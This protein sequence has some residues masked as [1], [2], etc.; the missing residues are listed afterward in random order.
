AGPDPQDGV[1]AELA[2]LLD[3]DRDRRAAHP[4]RDRRNRDPGDGPGEG[5]VLAAEG[6][7]ASSLEKAGDDGG[8]GGVD[9]IVHVLSDVALGQPDVVFALRHQP[10]SVRRA[11]LATRSRMWGGRGTSWPLMRQ[12]GWSRPAAR[13]ASSRELVCMTASV[14]PASTWSPTWRSM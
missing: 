13:S 9:G 14:S 4:A 7:L 11:Q 5:P 12:A 2:H 6:D 10:L 3:A 8:P 1:D